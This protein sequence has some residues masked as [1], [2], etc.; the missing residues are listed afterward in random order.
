MLLVT[1]MLSTKATVIKKYNQLKNTLKKLSYTYNLKKSDTQKIQLTKAM[2]FMS[3]KD[4]EEKHVM[5]SRVIT[6]YS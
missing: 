1:I 2:D 4:T 3:S 6:Y 5:H